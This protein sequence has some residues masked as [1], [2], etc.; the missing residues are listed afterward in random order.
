MRICVPVYLYLYIRHSYRYLYRYICL[1]MYACGAIFYFQSVIATETQRYFCWGHIGG[2][3]FKHLKL[4][5]FTPGMANDSQMDM[6]AAIPSYVDEL[7]LSSAP[8]WL[9]DATINGKRRGW[10]LGMWVFMRTDHGVIKMILGVHNH[11]ENTQFTAWL[12]KYVIY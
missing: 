7:R 3:L 4:Y 1:Y 6:Y 8:L 12:L 9:P 2:C 11:F 10:T 5:R